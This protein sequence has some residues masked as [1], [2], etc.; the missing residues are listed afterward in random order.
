MIQ[1]NNNPEEDNNM[2]KLEKA[3]EQYNEVTGA[4]AVVEDKSHLCDENGKLVYAFVCGE[5]DGGMCVKVDRVVTSKLN[6]VLEGNEEAVEQFEQVLRDIEEA[7]TY[8]LTLDEQEPLIGLAVAKYYEL[9]ESI[10]LPKLENMNWLNFEE[11]MMKIIN[12]IEEAGHTDYVIGKAVLRYDDIVVLY[13]GQ[14]EILVN[15]GQTHM[16]IAG[17][18]VMNDFKM[19]HEIVKENISDIDWATF[20]YKGKSK[21]AAVKFEHYLELNRNNEIHEA[22]FM[23]V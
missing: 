11:A 18:K 4:N 5:Y 16:A 17:D 10:N 23:I 15:N 14:R 12:H 19:L 3:I 21:V 2:L 6:E 1:K 20:Q 13:Q 22:L 9:A 7:K 8:R